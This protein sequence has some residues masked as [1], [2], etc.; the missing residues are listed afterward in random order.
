MPATSRN[1]PQRHTRA[2]QDQLKL[3]GIVDHASEYSRKLVSAEEAVGVVKSGDWM[4]YGHHANSPAYLDGFLAKRKDELRGVKVCAVVFPGLAQV[5]TC[6]P[7]REHFVYNNWHFGP[8][9]RMLHDQGLCNYIP[10]LYHEGRMYFERYLKPDVA[11]IKV[12]P[13]DKHGF[14]NFGTGNSPARHHRRGV[15]NGGGRGQRQDAVCLRRQRYTRLPATGT[16][17][18]PDPGI[19]D[20]RAWHRWHLYA[21]PGS[22]IHTK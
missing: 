2:N 6:D 9:D 11:M 1:T 3:S 21:W 22:G 18:A 15:G 17:L 19:G 5:A 8:G 13:M 20:C 16:G 14:F 7:S 10:I 4:Q 12:A